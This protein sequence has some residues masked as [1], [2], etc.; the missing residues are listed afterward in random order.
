LAATHCTIPAETIVLFVVSLIVDCDF[1]PGR[2]VA[3]L[4]SGSFQVRCPLVVVNL[5]GQLQ[6]PP[7]ILD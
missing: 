2:A 6:L 3:D 5:R 1:D 7:S 4:E